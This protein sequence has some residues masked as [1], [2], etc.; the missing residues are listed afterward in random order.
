MKIAIVGPGR[1]GKDEIADWL[2]THTTLR[3]WGSCSQVILPYAAAEQGI[4]EAEAWATRHANR[5]L[6]FR[7][8]NRL[9]TG[10]HAALARKTLENG[11]ICVGVR[12]RAEMQSVIDEGLVDLVLWVSRRGTPDDPT[13]EFGPELADI[14]I[15]NHWGLSELHGRL[16]KLAKSWGVLAHA[17][18]RPVLYLSGPMSGIDDFNFPAFDH[19]AGVL[20]ERGYRV[21]N[22]ADFGADPRH[23]WADCLGRDLYLVSQ[24][25][26]VATLPDW[27]GSRGA[28]L[29]VEFARRA[30]MKVDFW[31]NW[32]SGEISPN[33]G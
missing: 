17:G 19:A 33:D 4:G 26:G 3:Y 8:G 2:K 23:T 22:P 15:G 6:W 31:E 14:V 1:S 32:R 18:M 16:A 28:S 27:E 5:D 21:V 12:A 25:H 24:C 7:I 30:G 29:E 10:D 11:D 9:R 13:L 20:R